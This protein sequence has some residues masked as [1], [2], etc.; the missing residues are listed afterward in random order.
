MEYTIQ[1]LAGLSGVSSRTLR[2]YD[3][4]GLLPPKRI[5][6]SGY[7]IYGQAEVDRLQQILFLKK[8]GVKLEEIKETLEAPGFD[9]EKLLS[10]QRSLLEQQLLQLTSLIG[11]LDQTLAYYKGEKNMTDKEKFTAFKKEQL[12]ENEAHYGQEIREKYGE[13]T[14]AKANQKWLN[15]TSEEHQQMQAAEAQ[16]F[17]ALEILS[18]QPQPVDLDSPL[19]GQVFKAHKTW[20]TLVAPFY[21]NDY[22]RGLADMYV[23]DE[24]F[25]AY[26]NQRTSQPSV[27]LLH[28]IIFHYTEA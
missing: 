27:T 5:N 14:V 3:E 9:I 20:L 17:S 2:Y 7:R 21:N 25:A 12:Q 6:S 26:Y 1:K 4:I 15:L 22:H 28:D 16:L 19:A 18:S 23:N 13:E 11:R 10:Q 24:R 8:F